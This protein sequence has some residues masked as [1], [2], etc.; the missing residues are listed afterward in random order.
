MIATELEE[1]GAPLAGVTPALNC[2]RLYTFLVN[3]GTRSMVAAAISWPTVEL[4]TS[5]RSF[6]AMT[7]ITS[8]V[9]PTRRLKLTV[10]TWS[11]LTVKLSF[12]TESK[13]LMAAV[14]S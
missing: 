12:A 8:L 3:N 14:T 6:G 4:L 9:L 11:T 5:T 2:T 1:F 10:L 7:V 13:P